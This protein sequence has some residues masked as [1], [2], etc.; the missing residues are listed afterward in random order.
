MVALY[1]AHTPPVSR[2]ALKRAVASD[3]FGLGGPEAASAPITS[4]EARAMA[5]AKA[6]APTASP[7]DVRREAVRD[8]QSAY[9]LLLDASNAEDWAAGARTGARTGA[10]AAD[11]E[12]SATSHPVES[13][14]EEIP[15]RPR[16]WVDA[17]SKQSAPSDN[18]SAMPYEKCCL[19]I[20]MRYKCAHGNLEYK[21]H[22]K[23]DPMGLALF[24]E[25]D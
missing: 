11:E 16:L 7:M 8:A 24:A 5:R 1:A 19:W 17:E 14:E 15:G 18:V 13:V 2:A 9:H 20:D 25:S 4:A 10:R 3:Q 21:S 23:D 12:G 6:D 22:G